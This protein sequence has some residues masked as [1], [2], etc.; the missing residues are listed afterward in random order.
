[1][2]RSLRWISLL[3]LVGLGY[4]AWRA[5]QPIPRNPSPIWEASIARAD[6]AV[7]TLAVPVDGAMLEAMVLRPTTDGGPI[8]A[9]VFAGGSGDGLFQNYAPGFLETYVQDIFLERGIAVVLVNKRGMGA[10]TG[11]WMNNTIEGRAADIQAVADF[12][13]AKPGIDANGVGFA[14]HSQGGWVVVHAATHDPNTAFVLNYMGPLR[15]PMD[16]FEFMWNAVYACDGLEEDA[17]AAK[18]GRKTWITEVGMWFGGFLPIGML[19]FDANFFPYQTEGLLAQ[20][21]APM[22]AVYGGHDILVNGPASEAYLANAFP[23]GIPPH[24]TA[25]TFDSLNHMGFRVAS[26]CSPSD[27]PDAQTPS[28]ELMGAL[29]TW[30]DGIGF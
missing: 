18:V 13:R 8:P 19:E 12:V 30:L 5:E 4:Y 10:S 23:D 27:G 26:Q 29:N 7:E 25:R 15:P 24:L 11:N 17:V 28:P 2:K 16:Q 1:M 3:V 6:I 9:V 21:N 14:G 20:V 22:F